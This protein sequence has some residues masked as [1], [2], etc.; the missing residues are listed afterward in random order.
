MFYCDESLKELEKVFAWDEVLLYLENLFND[1]PQVNILN[2]LI[3]FA[4]YATVEGPFYKSG[5]GI[6][7]SD[8]SISFWKKYIDIGEKKYKENP[9]YNFI[10]GYT[11]AM[12]GFFISE[13]YEQK[14]LFFIKKCIETSKDLPIKKL[15]ENFLLNMG[16]KHVPLVD[17]KRICDKLFDKE[18]LL[19]EYFISIFS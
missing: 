8:I 3:G 2:Y 4:W 6:E 1:S 13:Y 11:L 7:E 14:G 5:F 19:G 10:S 18:T 9:Y 17:G 12:D 16:K 15:A